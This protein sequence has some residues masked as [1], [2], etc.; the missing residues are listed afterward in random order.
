M[1][2]DFLETSL[3]KLLTKTEEEIE[4]NFEEDEEDQATS[5][6]CALFSCETPSNDSNPSRKEDMD[7]DPL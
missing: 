5:F 2:V 3:W 7:A 4:Q 6:S 1:I